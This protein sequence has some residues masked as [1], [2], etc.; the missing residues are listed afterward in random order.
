MS[1]ALVQV[2]GGL[3]VLVAGTSRYV[4]AVL[5]LATA[6]SM[7]VAEFKRRGLTQTEYAKNFNKL[8][9]TAATV[10]LSLAS[11]L[12][13]AFDPGATEVALWTGFAA[14][15]GAGS[16]FPGTYEELVE[17]DSK[18]LYKLYWMPFLF[19]FALFSVLLFVV[20]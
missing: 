10:A 18:G 1:E 13:L 12:L 8:V 14:L 15:I 4:A 5:A 7:I 20:T 6:G 17:L 11:A 9:A 16:V 19:A 3:P 2:I